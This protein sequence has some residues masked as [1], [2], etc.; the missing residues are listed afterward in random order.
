MRN[1]YLLLGEN[2]A[3]LSYGCYEL[4]GG[5]K[6]ASRHLIEES[7]GQHTLC[8]LHPP[9]ARVGDVERYDLHVVP[10]PVEALCRLNELSFSS[11]DTQNMDQNNDSHRDLLVITSAKTYL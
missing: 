1:L 3:K 10:T 6:R 2:L 4:K 7:T 5:P 8:L 9:P 11:A